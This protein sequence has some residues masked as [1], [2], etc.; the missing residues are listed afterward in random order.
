MNTGLPEMNHFSPIRAMPRQAPS[1]NWMP[2]SPPEGGLDMFCY[3]VGNAE[4]LS[5]KT[6]WDVMMALQHWGP[7]G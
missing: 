5:F 7:P 2:E 4:N 3:G 6:H 1:G